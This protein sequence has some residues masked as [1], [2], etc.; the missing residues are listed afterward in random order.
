[1]NAP[2]ADCL[3]VA[4]DR[5]IREMLAT[6]A[7]SVGLRLHTTAT[8]ESALKAM[9]QGFTYRISLVGPEV[10][11]AKSDY[12]CVRLVA[13]GRAGRVVGFG[14]RAGTEGVEAR[15]FPI[16]FAGLFH[17]LRGRPAA[18]PAFEDLPAAA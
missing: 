18:P 7:R 9:A 16:D 17:L 5:V 2:S 10:G 15:E 8:L 13:A 14:V 4:R 6:C 1:M 12:T 3:I 11:D